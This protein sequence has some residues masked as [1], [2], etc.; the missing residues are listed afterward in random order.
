MSFAQTGPEVDLTDEN[1]RK[2][3]FYTDGRKI[4]KSKDLSRQ[5]IAAH[6]DGG[7]LVSDEK[8]PQGGKMTRTFE[9]SADGQQLSE[10]VS[11]ENS[12]SKFP[13][14][15]RYVYDAAKQE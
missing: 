11:M 5:E 3:V 1:Y 9:L 14:T 2:L 13:F 15:L 12:R 6:W 7:K 10:I 4:E 8:S